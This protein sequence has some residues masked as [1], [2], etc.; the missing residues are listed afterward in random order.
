[1]H[2]YAL[3]Y[4]VIPCPYTHYSPT[5]LILKYLS[6]LL[7]NGPVVPLDFKV[8]SITLLWLSFNSLVVL[9]DLKI[10]TITLSGLSF[11]GPVCPGYLSIFAQS[12]TGHVI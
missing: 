2:P 1:M 12:P 3:T 6:G 7:F 4:T 9:L 8:L 11:N 5:G 10:S